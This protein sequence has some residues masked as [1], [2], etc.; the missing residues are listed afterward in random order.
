MQKRDNLWQHRDFVKLWLGQT[1]SK[2]GTRLDALT[3]VALISLGVSP[4]QLG[5]L[6][7]AASAPMLLVSLFAGVWVDRLRRRPV[8]I[9]ADVGR[10]LLLGSIPLAAVLGMLTLWQVFIVAALVGVLNVCFDVADH[11]YLPALIER[12]QLVDGNSK[13]EA[14]GEVVEL[15]APAAGGGLVQLLTAPIAVLIDALTFICS[16]LSIA[17]IRK[18]E[19]PPLRNKAEENI[20]REIGTGLH[21]LLGN[22]ILRALTLAATMDNFFGAG[23]FGTL[24]TY[25]GLNELHLSPFVIGLL[26]GAGGAGGLIG[27]IFAE[28]AAHRFGLGRAIVGA[29]LLGIPLGFLT[30]LASGPL[31]LV[32]MMM[33]SAQFFGDLLRNVHSINEVSLRQSIIPNRLL[34]RAAA[35]SNFLVGGV[36]PFGAIVAGILGQL[37]TARY[38]LLI[39]V[40]GGALSNLWLVYSPLPGLREQ[41]G[42]AVS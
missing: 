32:I 31:P 21:I 16:A 36:A 28:R 37:I 13:L 40:I 12:E 33:A 26:I 22:K 30:P 20:W 14:S 25:Y 5:W 3:F 38:A 7:V 9:V 1:I 11:S 24:Y 17:L 41:P 6:G 23:F 8:M 34:G 29:S 15:F 19:P 35:S 18:P 4:A 10:A 39:A 2:F 27:A 42:S